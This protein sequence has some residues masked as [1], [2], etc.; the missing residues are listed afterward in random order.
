M[1][2]QLSHHTV[3]GCNIRP[4]DLIASG[5]ISAPGDD[6]GGSLLELSW[7]GTRPVVLAN[8]EERRFLEDH[9]T[10]TLTGWCQGQGYRVGFGE[11][12][13]TILPPLQQGVR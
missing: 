3:T 9:D 6:G 8:G 12:S 10:V 5:T 7:N 1:H 4:G 11:V 13:G 2:Q